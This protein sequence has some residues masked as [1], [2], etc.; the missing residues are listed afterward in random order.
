M[1]PAK[2]R[3]R[4]R[5]TLRAAHCTAARALRVPLGPLHTFATRCY[6]PAFFSKPSLLPACTLLYC[7]PACFC[8]RA[9]SRTPSIPFHTII[10]APFLH[11]HT[12]LPPPAEKE[13]AIL[14]LIVGSSCCS[15]TAFAA[16]GLLFTRTAFAGRF[17]RYGSFGL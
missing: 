7:A 4:A 6:L 11:T 8:A 9:L 2:T 3:A 12:F 16:R 1:I 5:I 13:K 10:P 15:R 14:W 17:L